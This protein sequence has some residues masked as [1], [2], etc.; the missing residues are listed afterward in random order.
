MEKGKLCL[1]KTAYI[2]DDFEAHNF[3]AS[4]G[5]FDSLRPRPKQIPSHLLFDIEK[6]HIPENVAPP[7][8]RR[9]VFSTRN[10]SSIP[11]T[12][13]PLRRSTTSNSTRKSVARLPTRPLTD[14]KLIQMGSPF[15]LDPLVV[16]SD[17]KRPMSVD[18][19]FR[20][21]EGS[22]RSSYIPATFKK[23]P[24]LM[25]KTDDDEK[26]ILTLSVLQDHG[27]ISTSPDHCKALTLS[28]RGYVE[29]HKGGLTEL[30]DVSTLEVHMQKFN[31]LRKH[32]IIHRFTEFKYLRRWD[33]ALRRRKFH[34]RQKSLQCLMIQSKQEYW[35]CV[36][37]VMTECVRVEDD[38]RHPV[39]TVPPFGLTLESISHEL[40]R[41]CDAITD[42]LEASRSKISE[43][44]SEFFESVTSEVKVSRLKKIYQLNRMHNPAAASRLASKDIENIC[45]MYCLCEHIFCQTAIKLH[46]EELGGLSQLFGKDRQGVLQIEAFMHL[47]DAKN[48]RMKLPFSASDQALASDAAQI[49]I[50][51]DGQFVY[52]TLSRAMNAIFNSVAI[53]M[54]PRIVQA[55]DEFLPP[56]YLAISFKT[57][58]S[59][60]LPNSYDYITSHSRLKDAISQSHS[61]SLDHCQLC[62]DHIKPIFAYVE[63]FASLQIGRC[64]DSFRKYLDAYPQSAEQYILWRETVVKL[65]G[66]ESEVRSF[67]LKYRRFKSYLQEKLQHEVIDVSFKQYYIYASEKL[68]E[69]KAIGLKYLRHLEE[70][71]STYQQLVTSLPFIYELGEKVDAYIEDIQAATQ[72]RDILQMHYLDTTSGVDGT[73]KFVLPALN[74][75]LADQMRNHYAEALARINE[76]HSQHIDII[77]AVHSDFLQRF[78]S[79]EN[80]LRAPPLRNI[81]SNVTDV[82]K[83]LYSLRADFC[84]F[85]KKAIEISNIMDLVKLKLMDMDQLSQAQSV[86]SMLDE[87]WSEIEVWKEFSNRIMLSPISDLQNS[88]A[89]KDFSDISAKV[90]AVILKHEGAELVGGL[91]AQL[92]EFERQW[93]IIQKLMD[94]KMKKSHF[95]VLVNSRG[96]SIIV[97][98][99]RDPQIDLSCLSIH[100][101]GKRGVLD[102]PSRLS[103]I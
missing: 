31:M 91:K 70:E 38:L 56:E 18:C 47:N 12:I 13:P 80:Q 87:V 64:D 22:T 37:K 57:D 24:H 1:P 51:P 72:M 16:E 50:I 42:A 71:I 61:L 46:N 66:Q 100:D 33:H 9:P 95:D 43:I 30:T 84:E 60:C 101:L 75:H 78:K 88:T 62:L 77:Q 10:S 2:H 49:M 76:R 20:S 34:E 35:K 25:T 14:E 3:Q 69:L 36:Q 82:K 11:F 17:S 89:E 83:Q 21:A 15:R 93:P 32:T 103:N 98:H 45:R 48:V 26:V 27:Y 85:E 6:T 92:F 19:S 44:L 59:H 94:P 58:Y 28:R 41:R 7:K 68:T 86:L 54:Q 99:D 40:E 53:C 5:G 74:P 52:D 90:K 67:R 4:A 81:S 29:C 102:D 73:T 79:F 39:W 23:L 65:P 55:L 97:S 96:G 63:A 8:I